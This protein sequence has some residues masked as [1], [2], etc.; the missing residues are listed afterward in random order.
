MEGVLRAGVQ[1]NDWI[2][3]VAADD[4]D[5]DDFNDL[6]KAKGIL[7][8]QEVLVAITFYSAASFAGGDVTVRALI[9]D[10]IG[11]NGVAAQLQ[12]SDK[13]QLK[14]RDVELSLPE[15]FRLFKRFEIVLTS[16]GLD[17]DGREYQT[18]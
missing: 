18:P 5:T 10:G 14:E 15:F 17:L 3:T 12:S 11:F 16:K 9:A 6:L 13:L 4:A 1:Y 2:G 7:S 8:N